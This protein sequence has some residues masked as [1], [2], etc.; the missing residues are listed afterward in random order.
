MVAQSCTRYASFTIYVY[1]KKKKLQGP[2]KSCY[3]LFPLNW[4]NITQPITGW[5]SHEYPIPDS[6]IISFASLARLDSHGVT[7]ATWAECLT[8]ALLKILFVPIRWI[9]T[10]HTF[11]YW[12]SRCFCLLNPTKN[13]AAAESG[14]LWGWTPFVV[15]L[16]TTASVLHL[17]NWP[18]PQLLNLL[19]PYPTTHETTPSQPDIFTQ[20]HEQRSWLAPAQAPYHHSYAD[21]HMLLLQQPVCLGSACRHRPRNGV[22]SFGVSQVCSA[23]GA[24]GVHERS[25]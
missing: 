20:C 15:M 14:Q 4:W 11:R 6:T 21:S 12:S 16:P 24:S 19:Q 22:Y 23:L 5:Q 17:L 3:N 8:P 7:T 25:Q 9:C 10:C 18:V 2:L 1:I 13:K